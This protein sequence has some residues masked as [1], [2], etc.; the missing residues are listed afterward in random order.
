MLP[1]RD[2]LQTQRHTQTKSE[3]IEKDIS[4]NQQGERAGVAVLVSD[5]IDFK[6]KKITRN[7]EEHYIMIK[8][9][10]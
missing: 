10:V 1:I 9:S 7:K 8:G 5:K 2:S 6:A 3:G 4:C